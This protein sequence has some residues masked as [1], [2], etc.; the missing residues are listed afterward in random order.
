[1][2]QK[3][4][5]QNESRRAHIAQQD[6]TSGP[7]LTSEWYKNRLLPSTPGRF[8]PR[9]FVRPEPRST[10]RGGCHLFPAD[11]KPGPGS[12]EQL[13]ATPKGNHQAEAEINPQA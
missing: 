12:C 11:T 7:G 1:M 5:P 6:K 10:S 2:E 8:T 9:G 3:P 4:Y 13:E